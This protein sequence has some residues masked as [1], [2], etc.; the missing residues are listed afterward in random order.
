MAKYYINY[1]VKIAGIMLLFCLSIHCIHAEDKGI[2]SLKNKLQSAT[3]IDVIKIN[4]ELGTQFLDSL[5]DSAKY[6][7]NEALTLSQH[8]S[9]DTFCARCL[10]KIGDLNFNSGDY[11]NAI[12]NLYSA[13]QIFERL[14]DKH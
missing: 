8:V 7:F 12:S 9:N 5:P 3:A 1:F 14:G 2:D 4:Y 13:L 6:Y 10:N 11:K